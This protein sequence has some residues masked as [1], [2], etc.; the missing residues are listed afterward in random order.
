MSTITHHIHGKADAGQ[1]QRRQ[2]VTNP[3]TGAVTG[4]G[5]VCGISPY[6]VGMVKAPKDRRVEVVQSMRV[7]RFRSE[8]V[9]DR[10]DKTAHRP[11]VEAAELVVRIDAAKCPASTMGEHENRERTWSGGRVNAH[12]EF[13]AIC[14]NQTLRD[15]HSF[16]GH[17]QV[18]GRQS[19]G[20]ASGADVSLPG[21]RGGGIVGGA[22]H[23]EGLG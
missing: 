5:N 12:A 1:S 10:Y 17:S 9:I 20:L 8:R 22:D 4:H 6:F 21:R 11:R 7:G 23:G 15:A 3:A 16:E 18:I 13:L 2:A 19:M 14:G